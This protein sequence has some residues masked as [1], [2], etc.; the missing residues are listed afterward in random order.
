M[1]C[2]YAHPIKDLCSSTAIAGY[3]L[4][5]NPGYEEVVDLKERGGGVGLFAVCDDDREHHNRGT[6][7]C[8]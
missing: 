3:R 7:R 1:M 2:R 6:I 4:H 5:P 8:M